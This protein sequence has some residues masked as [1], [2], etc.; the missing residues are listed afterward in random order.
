MLDKVPISHVVEAQRVVIRALSTKH[1]GQ[2]ISYVPEREIDKKI[3]Y[4]ELLE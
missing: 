1:N 3:W 2:K 4:L